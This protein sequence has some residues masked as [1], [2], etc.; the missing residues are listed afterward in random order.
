M[1]EDF[2]A[3]QITKRPS[4]TG[5]AITAVIAFGLMIVLIVYLSK[6]SENASAVTEPVESSKQMRAREISEVHRRRFL[7]QAAV[8]KEYLVRA[9]PEWSLKAIESTPS[10][11][12]WIDESTTTEVWIG[13]AESGSLHSC[14]TPCSVLISKNNQEKVIAIVIVT[15]KSEDETLMKRALAVRATDFGLA[16]NGEMERLIREDERESLR[17]EMRDAENDAQGRQ[18]ESDREPSRPW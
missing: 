6:R 13:S 2:D 1:L 10:E 16:K 3:R 18:Y 9:Y 15:F 17:T 11:R 14:S 5:I 12:K 8:I 4:R 7:E